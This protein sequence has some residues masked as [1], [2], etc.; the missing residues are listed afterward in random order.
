MAERNE[1][2]LQRMKSELERDPAMS[3]EDLKAVA[4]EIDQKVGK[5][6][7]RQFNARY[8]LPLK[9]K[10]S[11]RKKRGEGGA[12]SKRARAGGT[13]GA[14]EAMRKVFLEF[15]KDLS[16]AESRAAIVEVVSGLDRYVDRALSVSKR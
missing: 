7:L 5:L 12:S 6:S 9:R 4:K 11:S 16:Q 8:V 15:A 14:R 3:V 1:A 2:V 13:N 10:K